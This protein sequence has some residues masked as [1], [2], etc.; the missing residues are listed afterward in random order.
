M[1]EKS[2]ELPNLRLSERCNIYIVLLSV[3]SQDQIL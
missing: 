3:I 1:G 2:A